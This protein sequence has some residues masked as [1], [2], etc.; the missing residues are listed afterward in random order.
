[1]N[2][3]SVFGISLAAFVLLIASSFLS[4]PKKPV[5]PLVVKS[6]QINSL[7][8]ILK[9][10]QKDEKKPDVLFFIADDM[11]S[12]DCE[13]Y[14]NPDVKTPNLSKLASQG[15]CFDN[16]NN[17]TAMCG[18]TRQS[19]Y[20]GIFPVKNGSYP[21]HSKVYDNV[22]SIFHHFKDL[23]YRVALIGKRH[24]A[25]VASF[26][27]EYLGGRDSDNRFRS[28]TLAEEIVTTAKE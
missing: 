28:N 5:K 26:P 4:E 15:I 19:L 16:M 9:A 17:A 18:P 1:M 27:F 10:A 22:I 13:P 21:N 6:N 12:V 2:K 11:T 20:T 25:P 14:G 24:T 23:G 7:N 3:V 8:T